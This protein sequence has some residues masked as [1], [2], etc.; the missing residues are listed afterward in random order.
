ME[1]A[2][3][4]IVAAERIRLPD[5]MSI[6]G[7]NY[8]V[9]RSKRAL[10]SG[11]A[12]S[13]EEFA[14]MAGERP[15]ALHTDKANEQHYELPAEFFNLIL[16]THR[17]YSCCLF[18]MPGMT[19]DQ[20]EARALA[21]TSSHA[22]LA[23]GQRILEMGCGWGSLSLWM[24]KHF[25][26][27]Q[28]T[29]VS[30]SHSQREYI[31]AQ[32]CKHSYNNL[33]VIT[34]D[35]NVFD[36]D[37]QFDRIVSVEMFEHMS[38]WRQLLGKARQWIRSDGRMFMHVFTHKTAAYLFDENDR[39]DWIAQHFFTGGIMPSRTLIRQYSDLFNIEEEQHWS[40]SHYAETARQWLLNYDA[41]ASE[42]AEILNRVY[43]PDAQ[44][45]Q[46]R[47]RLFFLATMGLFGHSNGGE[48]GVSHYRLAPQTNG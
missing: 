13:D 6:A 7:I 5:S 26:N 12:I 21:E 25:P 46:R 1:L 28:I 15:I 16:G 36:T 30:N 40:G 3:H 10:N 43:E 38:N 9:S 42:I 39:T 20:A 31:E 19:L 41:N 34:C 24:A 48:W 4:L 18:D 11:A 32:A 33:A 29:A 8:L 17:K 23:D 35:M 27:A 2:K 47:W 22:R 45:W 14:R 37:E 44:L